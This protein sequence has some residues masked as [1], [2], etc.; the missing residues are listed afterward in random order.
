[1]RPYRLHQKS[2]L[3]VSTLALIALGSGCSRHPAPTQAR[4]EIP[5][6]LSFHR[7]LNL[8]EYLRP[9]AQEEIFMPISAEAVL[10]ITPLLTNQPD[11]VNRT[12]AQI[13]VKI[14]AKRSEDPQ[15]GGPCLRDAYLDVKPGHGFTLD[16]LIGADRLEAAGDAFRVNLGDLN[17][18]ESRIFLADLEGSH[19]PGSVRL[20]GA[21]LRGKRASDSLL[22]ETLEGLS[23][24]WQRQATPAKLDKGAAINSLVLADAEALKG[25]GR[26]AEQGNPDDL[27]QAIS[28]VDLQL[29]SIGL[30]HGLDTD[31][32]DRERARFITVR[33]MLAD[34]LQ[35]KTGKV[36]GA[37]VLPK[38]MTRA[39]QTLTLANR[40]PVGPWITLARLL[41]VTLD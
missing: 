12:L 20:I 11:G 10:K 16:R 23:M 31:G 8:D 39:D 32:L 2:A 9:F 7:S 37:L 17:P 5:A 24:D 15:A 40:A 26:F 34:R 30:L 41:A 21:T 4:N 14:R 28:L 35:K 33:A 36:T 1:M 22:F 18:G 19:E 25:V 3:A 38:D 6:D 29:N 27:V 13:V